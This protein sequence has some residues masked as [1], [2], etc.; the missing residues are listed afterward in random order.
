MIR[1]FHNKDCMAGMAEYP[2]N[3]FDLAIV[4]PPYVVGADDGNFGRGGKK[5][6]NSFYRKDLKKYHSVLPNAEYFKELFRVSK[7]QIIWGANYYPEHLYHSGWIVWDKDK[8]DGLLSMAELAFQSLDKRVMIF[9]HAW[10]GF[11]RKSEVG[12]KTIHPNQKPVMLYRWLLANYGEGCD[13]ILDTHVGSA[14][15]LIAFEMEGFEYA[16]FEMDEDYY[17]A[18]TERIKRFRMQPDM[19]SPQPA[20]QERQLLR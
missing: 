13:K 5:A 19:F 16:G 18:A 4:D 14:S 17:K 20:R 8:K 10:E 7:N 11:R 9:R 1:E 15:S 12:V 3:Y 6:K 2:D